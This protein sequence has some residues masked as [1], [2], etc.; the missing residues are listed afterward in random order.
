[1]SQVFLHSSEMVIRER[2]LPAPR[3]RAVFPPAWDARPAPFDRLP[4]IA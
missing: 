3:E 2:G 1:M 4:K